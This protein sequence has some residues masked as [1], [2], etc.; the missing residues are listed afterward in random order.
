MESIPWTVN[1]WRKRR[2]AAWVAIRFWLIALLVGMIGFYIPFWL[3]REHVHV[4]DLDSRTRYT[5]STNDETEGQFILGLVS[6]VV[7]GGALMAIIFAVRRHYRC[8]K[9]NEIPMSTWVRSGP[10]SFGM[11]RDL[12]LFPATC[13]NCG[14]RLR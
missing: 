3:N 2:R 9:C 13:P 8:P 14:A 4:Q 6:L 1:A 7:A 11:H 12:A 5:L 10:G